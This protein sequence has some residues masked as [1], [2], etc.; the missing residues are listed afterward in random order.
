[1][2]R[3]HLLA[4]FLLGLAPTLAAGVGCVLRPDLTSD[5]RPQILGLA[6]MATLLLT[7]TLL[8]GWWV[9]RRLVSGRGLRRV[10]EVLIALAAVLVIG[11][12]GA[13]FPLSFTIWNSASSSPAPDTEPRPLLQTFPEPP[14]RR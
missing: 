2:T 1:M 5:V 11:V 14:P 7:L 9:A 12:P 8:A 10:V 3:A 13:L 6:A 4:A